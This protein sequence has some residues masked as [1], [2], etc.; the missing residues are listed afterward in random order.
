MLPEFGHYPETQVTE[1]TAA[2]STM[3]P[4]DRNQL[5]KVERNA[6]SILVIQIRPQDLRNHLS[7]MMNLNVDC[8]RD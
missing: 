2:G 8:R 5:L 1:V 3:P 4:N 6:R 7:R